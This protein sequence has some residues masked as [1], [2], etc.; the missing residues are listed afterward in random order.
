MGQAAANRTVPSRIAGPIDEARVVAL[1]GNVHPLARAEFDR[2]TLDAETGLG[3]MLLLLEPSAGQQAELDALVAAQ[4][5][6]QSPLYRKWLTPA[7]YGARFGV[8]AQDAAQVAAWLTG[9][10]FTVEEIPASNR[11]I[12]FSG[13]AG[14]VAETFHAEMHRYRV[15]YALMVTPA[16]AITLAVLPAALPAGTAGALYPR[17]DLVSVGGTAPY[18]YA[19]SSGALPAGLALSTAG[20]FSGT[21]AAAGSFT[22]TVTATDSSA[23]TGP[24]TGSQGYTLTINPSAAMDFTIG[25]ASGTGGSAAVRPG[26]TVGEIVTVSPANGA[27]TFANAIAFSASGLPAGATV[28]FSPASVPAG[29]G[30]TTVTLTIQLP[31]VSA[32]RGLGGGFWGWLGPISLVLLLLPL[33][34][35]LRRGG[36]GLASVLLLAIAGVAAMAGLSGCGTISGSLTHSS[37]TYTITVTG[38]S[39]SLSHS[40]TIALTVG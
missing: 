28:N 23:G 35:R 15:T 3:R 2:G 31:T 16:P 6:P 40:T 33:A 9:H 7:Q 34:G 37:Q 39:G 13:T 8:N 21:P 14:R 27:G 11:L 10:G 12:V 38:T 25:M 32:G 5:D 30:A 1:A 29:S 17:T 18:T 26:G 36:K 24:H 20:V 19:V 22:F 4:H